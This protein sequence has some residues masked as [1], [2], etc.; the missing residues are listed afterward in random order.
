MNGFHNWG[1]HA[2][3]RVTLDAVAETRSREADSS[4]DPGMGYLD[5]QHYENNQGTL[6]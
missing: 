5:P 2:S 3:S 1:V 4:T 6:I